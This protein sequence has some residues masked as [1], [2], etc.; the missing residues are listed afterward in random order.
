M[1]RY[2]L[3]PEKI[4]MVEGRLF[5]SD[6]DRLTMLGL[7]LENVGID[8]AVRLGDPGEWKAAVANLP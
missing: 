2:Q 7:L 3:T 6:D 5:W 1:A 8:A 4:E